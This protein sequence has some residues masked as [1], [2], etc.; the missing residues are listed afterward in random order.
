M[1]YRD[2]QTRLL[3]VLRD[4]HARRFVWGQADCCLFAADCAMAVCGQDPAADYRGQYDSELGAKKAL[5]RG[6]GS[7]VKAFG[8][9]FAEVSTRLVQR[10]DIVLFSGPYGATAGIWWSGR[11]WAMSDGGLVPLDHVTL[12]HAWRVE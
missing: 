2:W 11:V 3:Q 8:A 5:L 12:T 9:C 10:G 6:H 7:L 4:Y 1:R